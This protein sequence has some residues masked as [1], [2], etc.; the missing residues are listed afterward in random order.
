MG[1]RMSPC[2]SNKQIFSVTATE[3]DFVFCNKTVREILKNF[4]N[5]LT[6]KNIFALVFSLY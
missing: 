6:L 3:P 5:Q 1:H 4:K 2:I